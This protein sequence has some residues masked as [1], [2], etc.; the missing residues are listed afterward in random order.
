MLVCRG[1]YL[2]GVND[3]SLVLADEG[4][5]RLCA[6]GAVQGAVRGAE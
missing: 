2:T 3:V 1:S 5:R 6:L 4:F